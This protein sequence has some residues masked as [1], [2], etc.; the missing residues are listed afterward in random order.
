MAVVD[1]NHS[2]GICHETSVAIANEES[3][4]TR[5]A[6]HGKTCLVAFNEDPHVHEVYIDNEELQARWY[7]NGEYFFIKKEALGVVR[8][9]AK[10][11]IKDTNTV[12]TRGLEIVDD[13]QRKRRKQNIDNVVRCILDE[14]ERNGS[15]PKILSPLYQTLSHVCIMKSIEHAANDAKDAEQ[16]LADTKL[17]LNA[18]T[19]SHTK[20]QG[21]LRSFLGKLAIG[22]DSS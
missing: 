19:E 6:F 1:E 5:A 18:T 3:Q 13:S 22:K 11:N 20:R 8:R 12:S 17:Y 14:Q 10:T 4:R 16:Y 7:S 21:F 9:M 15:D 2:N